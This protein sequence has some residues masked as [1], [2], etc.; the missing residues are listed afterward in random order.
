MMTKL[1]VLC[2]AGALAILVPSILFA[3]EGA[4]VKSVFSDYMNVRAP[5][6][7]LRIPGLDFSSSVG[8]SFLSGS[9]GYSGGMGYYMGHFNLQLSPSLVL[10]WDVGVGSMMTGN[11]QM[12]ENPRLLIPNVDL[13]YRPSDKLSFRLQFQQYRYPGYY[14]P[15][16]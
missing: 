11:S 9:G 6:S 5:Q 3:Q 8:F 13:T 7:F 14:P 16:R 1:R 2:A 4:P 15:G 10:R 12:N